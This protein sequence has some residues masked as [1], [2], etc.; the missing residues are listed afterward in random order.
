MWKSKDQCNPKATFEI[1]ICNFL[2][3]EKGQNFSSHTF[4]WSVNENKLFSSFSLVLWVVSYGSI[5]L[6]WFHIVHSHMQTIF[7]WC[8]WCGL[9]WMYTCVANYFLQHV[10]FGA[11]VKLTIRCFLTIRLFGA[12]VIL[13]YFI[14]LWVPYWK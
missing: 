11:I 9:L 6:V 4:C 7:L 2:I 1:Y 10:K 3:D 12:W 14:F 8:G 13:N 5:L